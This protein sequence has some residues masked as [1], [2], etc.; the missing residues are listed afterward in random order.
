MLAPYDLPLQLAV[1]PGGIQTIGIHY[2]LQ[3]KIIPEVLEDTKGLQCPCSCS[4][5]PYYTQRAA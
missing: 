4:T 1:N 3:L 5:L 2:D